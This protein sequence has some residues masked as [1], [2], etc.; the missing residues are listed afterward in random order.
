MLFNYPHKNRYSLIEKA[1]KNFSG[2][3]I[4]NAFDIKLKDIGALVEDKI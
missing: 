4:M 2:K 1:D 3:I